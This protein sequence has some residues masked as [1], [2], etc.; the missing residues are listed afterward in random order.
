MKVIDATGIGYY[1]NIIKGIDWAIAN[2]MDVINMSFCGREYSQLLHESIIRAANQGIIVVAAS[3]NNGQGAET[4]TYPALFPEVVSVGSVNEQFYRSDFSSTGVQLDLMA[5]GENIYTTGLS[6]S[7]VYKS[8]TSMAA[9]Y[10][11]GAVASLLSYYPNYSASQIKNLLYSTATPLG[12][13]QEYGYGLINIPKALGLSNETIFPEFPL[14]NEPIGEPNPETGTYGDVG[15]SAIKTGDGQKVM[16]GNSVS[17]SVKLGANK[18]T[19]LVAVFTPDG[20]NKIASASYTNKK[21]NESVYFTWN[22]T[23]ALESGTYKIKFYYNDTDA[24]DLFAIHVSPYV[25]APVVTKGT[26]TSSSASISWN[27]VTNATGYKITC[28]GKEYT[29]PSNQVSQV[30]TGLNSNTQYTVSVKAINSSNLLGD[31]G[32]V[33]VTT[34]KNLKPNSPS[35]KAVTPTSN[36]IKLEWNN[37]ENAISYDIF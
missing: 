13:S 8:G 32:T 24:A 11:T 14:Q 29:T 18:A 22:T 9:P 10:V 7:Y 1:S 5:P 34:L 37:S 21:Q 16:A 19:V 6:N 27:S 33:E 30:L 4:E 26:V 31:E 3:G 20:A 15:I 25:S 35:I 23:K 28:Y 2:N 36:Q 12:D 17:V